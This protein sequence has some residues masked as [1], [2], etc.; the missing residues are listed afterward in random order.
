MKNERFKRYLDESLVSYVVAVVVLS[1]MGII[2]VVM[3]GHNVV[4]NVITILI[5]IFLVIAFIMFIEYTI[6]K[7]HNK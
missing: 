5:S 2:Y 4:F 7:K 3:D 6:W 1:V